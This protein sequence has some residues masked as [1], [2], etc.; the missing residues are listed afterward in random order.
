MQTRKTEQVIAA[1]IEL[2]GHCPFARGAFR[3]VID[4]L[5]CCAAFLLG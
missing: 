3:K 1:L 4:V 5:R 2:I